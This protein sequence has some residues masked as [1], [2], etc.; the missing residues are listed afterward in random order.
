MNIH[1][2]N[3]IILSISFSILE[4]A[5][6][7]ILSLQ[8]AFNGTMASYSTGAFY[9]TFFSSFVCAPG[10]VHPS[11]GFGLKRILLIGMIFSVL[12]MLAQIHMTWYLS[13]PGSVVGGFGSGLMWTAQGTYMTLIA[14][15]YAQ[16]QGVDS[17]TSMGL[18][19][20]VFYSICQASAILFQLLATLVL[21]KGMDPTTTTLEPL[22]IMLYVLYLGLSTAG[23]GFM[24]MYLP[25]L[26]SSSSSVDESDHHRSNGHPDGLQNVFTD[27]R[28]KTPALESMI[29]TIDSTPLYYSTRRMIAA[30][31]S[32]LLNYK[33]FLLLPSNVVFGL[34]QHFQFD[35]YNRVLISQHVGEAYIGFLGSAV[36]FVAMVAC[37][38]LGK[39]SDTRR[40]RVPF[41][42]SQTIAVLG[43]IA[44][45]FGCGSTPSWLT[46]LVLAMLLGIYT[47]LWGTINVAL[48]GDFFPHNPAPAFANLNMWPGVA[49]AMA[50]FFYPSLSI[51]VQLCIL[52]TF[53]ILGCV[54]GVVAIRRFEQEQVAF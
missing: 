7:G 9:C 1:F 11:Q 5:V 40:S 34:I 21:W 43:L 41:F 27:S 28:E 17:E 50:F 49:A 19:A 12:Y 14:H 48:V 15:R 13:F 54:T 52:G 45:T 6:V 25:H 10:L 51:T 8:T 18:F 16:D 24:A 4:A 20:G 36:S 47:A 38:P 46:L 44:L 31:G 29:S 3:L 35:Y 32:N 2:K 37:A 42:I 39:W 33:T 22:K 30:T 23:V 26:S 53:T